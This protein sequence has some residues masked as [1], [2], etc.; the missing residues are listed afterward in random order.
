MRDAMRNRQQPIVPVECGGGMP[1]LLKDRIFLILA[2]SAVAVLILLAVQVLA[3]ETVSVHGLILDSEMGAVLE[4]DNG[5]IY[6]LEGPDLSASYD[7]LATVT[8]AFSRDE[9]G[10]LYIDVT[11]VVPD[12]ES[13][14]S[15]SQGGDPLNMQDE[16]ELT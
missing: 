15:P 1:P 12:L 5:D 14:A 4:A 8:G 11:A 10:N 2:A 16:T 3:A 9:G 6:I 13:P 7:T